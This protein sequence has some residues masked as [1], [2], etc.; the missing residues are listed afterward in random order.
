[1]RFCKEVAN[2]AI[3]KFCAAK[4]VTYAEVLELDRIIEDFSDHVILAT[5]ER[6]N[7]TYR[8]QQ[9]ADIL[10]YIAVHLY[11]NISLIHV[12]RGFFAEALM[13]FP[14]NPLD[15]PFAHSFSA[16]YRGSVK[17]LGVLRTKFDEL[18]PLLIRIWPMWAH[19]LTAAV[20]R[21]KL[22]MERDGLR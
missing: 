17:L 12:H 14:S 3:E 4:P 9:P 6:M 7:Q 21:Q 15:S 20:S 8:R 19:S 13:K 16:A 5:P 11:R 10:R 22:F 18:S 2:F 1:M